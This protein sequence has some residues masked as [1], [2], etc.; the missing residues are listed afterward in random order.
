[1]EGPTDSEEQ[2]LALKSADLA[3]IT[4]PPAERPLCDLALTVD[5]KAGFEN[6]R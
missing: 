3:K 2:S 1:M 6:T 4:I 5:L